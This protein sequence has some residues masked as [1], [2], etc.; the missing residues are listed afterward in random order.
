MQRISRLVAVALLTAVVLGATFMAGFAG[1][2]WLTNDRPNADEA[3]EFSVFWE[4]WHI[5]EEQF[6]GELPTTKQ[7]TYAA[8]RGAISTLND[9][10]TTFVEPQPRAL[11]KAELEGRFGGIGA[12]VR[13]LEDGSIAL[14]PMPDS[15]AAEAG[16]KDGDILLKVDDTVITSTMGLDEVILLIR[17]PVDTRVRLTL[18]RAGVADP[19]VLTVTRKVIETPSVEWRILEE[20]PTIGYIHIRLFS[21]R[22]GKELKGA[23][24]DLKEKQAS[25]FILDFRDNGGGLVDAAVEVA[26]QFLKEGVI[27]YERQRN[28]EEKFYPVRGGGLV[29]DAPLVLLVN[30]GT[31]SASEIVAGAIQDQK[32]GILIGEHTYGK[33]SVQFVYDLGDKSSIH[34]TVARW[35][36]PNRHRIDGQGLTPDIELP[37][38]DEDR[39]NHRDPQLARAIAYLQSKK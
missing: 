4:A 25:R 11:E 14:S 30:K 13:K 34:V 1:H 17:G 8:I 15:P 2:W 38:T 28:A 26:S 19:V 36:T 35:L 39:A 21:E 37:L 31:A 27:F 22:T 23:L 32:R 24:N 16:L 18:R 20:D 5:V 9:P 29:P 7:M 33:G 10:Y 6:Y 3:Q 12:Y